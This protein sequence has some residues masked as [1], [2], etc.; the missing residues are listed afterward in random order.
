MGD[1]LDEMG[2]PYGYIGDY[3]ESS[4]LGK[5]EWTVAIGELCGKRREAQTFVKDVAR[6]YDSIKQA[7]GDVGYRPK[8]MLNAPYKDVWFLPGEDSYMVSLLRDAGADYL[9]NGGR[10]DMSLPVSGEKAYTMLLEADV[11]LNP[12]AASS[13]EELAAGNSRFMDVPA[14][15][16]GKVFNNNRRMTPSGGS[17]FWES[18][19]VHPDVVLSDLV[20]IFHPELSDCSD[21]YY[22]KKLE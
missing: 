9:G 21:T 1:K 18:G 12:G 16:N 19:V 20:K 17:D 7:A 4:A 2:I 22:Y 13:L 14:V 11:W 5:A 3:L 10:R 6:R 15:E 8:A